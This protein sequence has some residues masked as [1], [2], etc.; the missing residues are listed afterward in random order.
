[1]LPS[2]ASQQVSIVNPGR[3]TE[4]GADVDDWT[5]AT[6]TTMRCVWESGVNTG[7]VTLGG[8]DVATGVRTV[9][10]NP[11]APVTGR[12]RIR[13]P[14]DPGRDWEVIGEPAFNRSPTGAVSNIT[15]SCRRWEGKQ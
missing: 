4:W 6:V 3:R 11:G 1:M 14:D 8:L 7:L 13:F 15:V 9:Y 10:L 12:S 2:F 5:T